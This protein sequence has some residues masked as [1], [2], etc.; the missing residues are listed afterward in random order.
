M[1]RPSLLPRSD[2]DLEGAAKAKK[3][4]GDVDFSILK[5]ASLFKYKSMCE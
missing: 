2:G 5:L 1:A 3:T 4:Y